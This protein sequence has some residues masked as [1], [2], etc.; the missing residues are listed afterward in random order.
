MTEQPPADE[1]PEEEAGLPPA[2]HTTPPPRGVTVPVAVPVVVAL[3][4][5]LALG[6]ILGW[7]IPR[8]GGGGDPV[9]APAVTTDG[10]A[11][12][13][14]GA[15]GGD[16]GDTV[17]ES[18]AAGPVLNP[19]APQPLPGGPTG[20]EELAGLVLGTTGPV[21]E[22]FEDYVCPFCARLETTSGAELRD[23]ALAG[24]FRLVLHPIAFLTEDSPRAAN[25]SA[26]VYEH[27]EQQ[28]WIAYHEALYARQD[29]SEAVG[30]YATPVLL[31]IASEVG[32]DTPEVTTCIE[33]GTFTDWVAALTQQA[34]SRGVTGTPTVAVEGTVTDPSPLLQ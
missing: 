8:P 27:A 26:C 4:L 31:E 29:P 17:A 15:T 14:G 28:T 19:Q 20:T 3:V 6:V 2:V 30:Q 34:F 25:A 11:E 22:L 9:A 18:P 7:L 1:R 23:A 24:E 33:D 12:D 32:A 21:V 13:T 10:A 16:A 5:G